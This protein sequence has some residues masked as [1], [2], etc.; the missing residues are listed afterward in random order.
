MT[1]KMVLCKQNLQGELRN[2]GIGVKSV[3][4]DLGEAFVA[5]WTARCAQAEEAQEGGHND[6]REVHVERR[7]QPWG[8]R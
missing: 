6:A 3:M 5:A 2:S 4:V 7:V 1:Y 8:N